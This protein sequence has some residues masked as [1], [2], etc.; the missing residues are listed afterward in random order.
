MSNK[1]GDLRVWWVPQVPG[2]QFKVAV[3]SVTQAIL[4]L[5]TLANYDLFQLHNNIKP[6]FCNAGGL[7]VFDEEDCGEDGDGW[8]EWYDEEGRDIDEVIR[9]HAE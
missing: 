2:A 3:E 1:Q 5:T 7:E 4:V 8:S 9:E 6:D